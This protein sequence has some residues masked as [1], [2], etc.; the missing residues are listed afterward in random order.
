MQELLD[1]LARRNED[2]PLDLAALQVATI[3]HPEMLAEPYLGLLDSHATE[4]GERV[5]SETTGEEFV[6]LLN[7]Y[8]VEELGFR[9]NEEDYYNP[10]NSCL[11]SVLTER[12]GIPITL[13]V[14]YIEIA[15]RLDRP[16]YGI[17]LPGHFLVQYDDGEFS[18]YIDP[19]N[20]GRLLFEQECLT[21]ATQVTGYDVSADRSVLEPV[22]KRHTLIRMLNNMRAVYFRLQDPARSSAVLDLLI[23]AEPGAPDAYKHRGICRAQ[24]ELFKGA[25]TDFETYLKL[26]PE[27]FDRAEV[28]AQIEKMRRWLAKLN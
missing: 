17:G 25:R 18:T 2:V 4:L 9:G 16:I 24:M 22:S 26:E 13:S 7:Q 10:A 3:E 12:A 6:A 14:L 23:T 8:L 27:A 5:D 21:L 15:R 1:L 28:E 11:D 20:G 19:F